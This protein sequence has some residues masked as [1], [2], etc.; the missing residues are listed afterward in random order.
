MTAV[1]TLYLSPTIKVIVFIFFFLMFQ[2]QAERKREREKKKITSR[3]IHIILSS[4]SY[5]LHDMVIH[6]VI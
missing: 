4:T 3:S 1:S 5:L 6:Q 2:K